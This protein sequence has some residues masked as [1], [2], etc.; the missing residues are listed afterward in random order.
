MLAIC[1]VCTSLY[2]GLVLPPSAL[3][4]LCQRVLGELN[5]YFAVQ[6]TQSRNSKNICACDTESKTQGCIM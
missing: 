1:S 6:N 2:F 4:I 3:I 5:A